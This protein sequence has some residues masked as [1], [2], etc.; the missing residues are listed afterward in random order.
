QKGRDADRLLRGGRS[1]E[2]RIPHRGHR[3]PENVRHLHL[4]GDGGDQ[5]LKVSRQNARTRPLPANRL[6]FVGI[7]QGAVP[8]KKSHLFRKAGAGQILRPVTPVDQPPLSPSTREI[9]VSAAA[10][11]SNPGFMS[12][13]STSNIVNPIPT[14]RKDCKNTIL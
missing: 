1:F 13:S 10:T 6:P 14:Y 11:P 9:F 4:P 8:Q 7:G 2:G 5:T 3:R 12:I